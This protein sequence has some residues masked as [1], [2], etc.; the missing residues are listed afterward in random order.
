MPKFFS[1]DSVHIHLI[2]QN[3]GRVAISQKPSSTLPVRPRPIAGEA[4]RGYLLR[5]AQANGYETL[6]QLGTVF[7]SFEKLGQALYL[8]VDE[9]DK[10]FGPLPSFW[11]PT[12][13]SEGLSAGDFNHTRLRWC[14]KCLRESVYLRGLW[15]VEVVSV[16]TRHGICLIDQCHNCESAQGLERVNFVQ[17]C[18][19]ASLLHTRGVEKVHGSV[20]SISEAMESSLTQ[21]TAYANFPPLA[22]AEWI[23]L[24]TYLGQFSESFQPTKPGKIAKLYQ[25]DTAMR[26][27]SQIARLLE[28]W[29]KNFYR[30]LST[31]HRHDEE[32]LSI[33][34]TFG[35]LYRVLYTDMPDAC[36][37]FLR[38][39]FEH[40]LIECWPGVVCGRH[41]AFQAETIATHPRMAWKRAAKQAGIAPSIVR[42]LIRTELI[43]ASEIELPSGRTMRSIEKKQLKQLTDLAKAG[44]TLKEAAYRLALPESRVRELINDEIIEPLVSRIHGNAAAWLIPEQQ[45]RR[46]YFNGHEMISVS[47]TITTGKILKHWRLREGEFKALVQAL[48]SG[49]L[50]PVGTQAER[51]P[52]GKLVFV[53]FQARQWLTEIRDAPG[54]SLSVDEAA[55]R[56]G[57][58]QQVVYDLVKAGLLA[59]P[60]EDRHG[61]RIT[62]AALKAF[63]ESY[64]SLAEYAHSLNRAPRSVLQSLEVQPISGPMIDG[65]RQYFYRRA[66]LCSEFSDVN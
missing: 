15:S 39:V 7:E 12:V 45:L 56:L 42:H 14:P 9:K 65:S 50:V 31:L 25:V 29:P 54:V 17:C 19:G 53:E 10:L 34:K 24:I 27:T 51:T 28:D 36:F 35:P 64:I 32:Q 37:Q 21:K 13:Y 49:R 58:K 63:R 60:Q 47:A 4:T 3:S 43:S 59:T 16:C 46:L 20:L 2:R 23:R 48:M 8:T 22:L 6:A 61:R 52:L 41:R 55:K 40:Y 30:L 38:D 44:F 5:V 57:L 18:C 33:R 1:R 26:L 62:P 11:G 66:D